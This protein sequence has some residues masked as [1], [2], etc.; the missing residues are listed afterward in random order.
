MGFQAHLCLTANF[1]YQLALD[2]FLAQIFTSLGVPTGAPNS[3]HL[4]VVITALHLS[5]SGL[6]SMSS[7]LRTTLP[8]F[9]QLNLTL[10][11]LKYLQPQKLICAALPHPS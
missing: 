11:Y 1:P 4:T 10:T 3:L 6:C 9:R 5:F 8:N 7:E 2:E